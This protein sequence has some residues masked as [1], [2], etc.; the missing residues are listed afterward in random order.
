[1]TQE[2]AV[3]GQLTVRE[4]SHAV[5]SRLSSSASPFSLA[6]NDVAARSAVSFRASPVLRARLPIPRVA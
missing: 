6:A 2:P 1:M 3:D 4:T 5:P